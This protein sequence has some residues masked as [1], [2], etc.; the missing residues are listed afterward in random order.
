MIKV[1]KLFFFFF[2]SIIEKHVL[3]ASDYFN[4]SKSFDSFD[5]FPNLRLSPISCY[6]G[7]KNNIAV[8]VCV[9]SGHESGVLQFGLI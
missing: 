3:C 8:N 1:N 9:S 6:I 4:F 5:S 7:N 2:I